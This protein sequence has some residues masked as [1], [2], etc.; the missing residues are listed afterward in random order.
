MSRLIA[1]LV[2]TIVSSAARADDEP[3][4]PVP[5]SLLS[6]DMS[7]ETRLLLHT[8]ADSDARRNRGMAIAGVVMSLVGT[9]LTAG[10]VALT[11][12]GALCD[13]CGGDDGGAQLGGS[14]AMMTIGPIAVLAGIPMWAVGQSRA[15]DA[16]RA[17]I[18]LTP[19]GFRF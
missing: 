19:T 16:E 13:S 2:L 11:M 9:A 5:A 12:H 8:G 14:I 6:P 17:K 18:V 1:V 3:R 10:G 4:V 7:P 15:H